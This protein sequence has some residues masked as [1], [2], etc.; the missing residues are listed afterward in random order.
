V[1]RHLSF[2]R[3]FSLRNLR[4]IREELKRLSE[5]EGLLGTILISAEGINGMVTGS[6]AGVGALRHWL[7]AMGVQ[8]IKEHEAEQAF[9]RLLVKIKKEIISVGDPDLRPGESTAPRI[10]PAELKTWLDEGR[11]FRLLDTRNAYE[12]EVGTFKGA[13]HWNLDSSREFAQKAAGQ[14]PDHRPV[15]T[16]CTGGIRCEKASALLQKMGWE[17]VYQLDG[18]ILGYFEDVGGKY[19]EGNCFVFD[20][21]LAVDGTLKPVPRSSDTNKQFGRHKT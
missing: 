15:V 8:E 14:Q 19:F 13:E 12:V 16:F 11:P 20:W 3:F 21:R 2:Y 4:G 6:P 9:H 10:S 18:G 5:A 7:E 17:N 1:K